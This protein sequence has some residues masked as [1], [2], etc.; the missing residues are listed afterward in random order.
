MN[1]CRLDLDLKVNFESAVVT[2]MIFLRCKFVAYHSNSEQIVLWHKHLIAGWRNG[3]LTLSAPHYRMSHPGSPSHYQA[4]MYRLHPHSLLGFSISCESRNRRDIHKSLENLRLSSQQLL[5]IKTRLTQLLRPIK[6]I[7]IIFGLVLPSLH[8]S[9][10]Y[11]CF[12]EGWGSYH[13]NFPLKN[14]L[15]TEAS[16]EPIIQELVFHLKIFW[17]LSVFLHLSSNTYNKPAEKEFCICLLWSIRWFPDC[18]LMVQPQQS[19]WVTFGYSR[20]SQLRSRCQ[21]EPFI[22]THQE[23]SENGM[24]NAKQSGTAVSLLNFPFSAS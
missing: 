7:R 11:F 19:Q 15:R 10:K 1:L 6:I 2:K 13:L 9:R 18:L 23:I 14:Y 22:R 3:R 20:Q 24:E 16:S 5:S 8:A 17:R 4:C 12:H 21:R